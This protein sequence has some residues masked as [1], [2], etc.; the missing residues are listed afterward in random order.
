MMGVKGEMSD[1]FVS[2]FLSKPVF[3]KGRR[4]STHFLV[5]QPKR[6][7]F[8]AY[9]SLVMAL[10]VRNTFLTITS[11]RERVYDVA[12]VPCIILRVFEEFDPHVRNCHGKAVVKPNAP[13]MCRNTK[14]RHPRHIFSNGDDIGEESMQG[15][16]C[17]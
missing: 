5:H 7:C 12:H 13:Y 4:I 11:V 6:E 9:K 1:M 16:I 10:C 2:I 8:I 15:V 17:L 3:L 14:K